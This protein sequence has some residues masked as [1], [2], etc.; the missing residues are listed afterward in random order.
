M[1]FGL[2]KQ[3]EGAARLI[4]QP[5]PG[6]MKQL[7]NHNKAQR[8]RAPEQLLIQDDPAR[9]HKAGGIDGSTLF[10]RAGE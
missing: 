7:M 9:T 3:F 2:E 5:R 4:A 8:S 1:E 6:K 10:R